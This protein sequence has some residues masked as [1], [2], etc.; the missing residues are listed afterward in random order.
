[1]SEKLDSHAKSQFVLFVIHKK[2]L[3]AVLIR[4]IKPFQ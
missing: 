2:S 1:M 4:V 3:I